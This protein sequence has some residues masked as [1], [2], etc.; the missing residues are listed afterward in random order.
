MILGWLQMERK[1][2]IHISILG[3]LKIQ[4]H[5]G[6]WHGSTNLLE[7]TLNTTVTAAVAREYVFLDLIKLMP[8]Q[9][10]P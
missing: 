7:L 4:Y 10:P 3:K 9:Y 5:Q 1:V 6:T 2:L 8:F